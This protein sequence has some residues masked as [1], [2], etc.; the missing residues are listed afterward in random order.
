VEG[1]TDDPAIE[2][3][4]HRQVKNLL[5]ITLLSLGAPMITM[6]DEMR[7]TQR[8]NNNAYCQDNEISWLDWS[9]LERYGDVHRFVRELV[10]VRGQR[11][12]VRNGTRLSLAELHERANVR[13]H[14]VR[15]HAPDL[16]HASR[17]LA[18]SAT[19]LEGTVHMY[20]VLSAYWEPLSFELPSPPR[21]H[22]GA[23]WRRVL[24]TSLPS[25]D[26]IRPWEEASPVDGSIYRVGPRSVVALMA[27]S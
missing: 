8:G 21:A 16:T 15:L 11:D 20:F 10:R 1:P 22:E 19:T 23:R 6:G 3:L 5:A 25:P 26:D 13:L 4:R 9:L 27:P 24:D 12:A 2:A 14:G 17:S 7:R 18:L